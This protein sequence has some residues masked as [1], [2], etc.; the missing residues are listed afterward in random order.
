LVRKTQ[1]NTDLRAGYIEL[2][3][4]KQ[5]YSE[6]ENR[7]P[8]YDALALQATSLAKSREFDSLYSP[9]F[10]DANIR[11]L[12][13]DDKTGELSLQLSGMSDPQRRDWWKRTQATQVLGG[14]SGGMSSDAS[15]YTIESSR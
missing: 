15:G 3:K 14:T 4:L 11:Q 6:A 1:E 13:M 9:A 7:Q 12:L 2:Q 10:I 5:K 8:Y